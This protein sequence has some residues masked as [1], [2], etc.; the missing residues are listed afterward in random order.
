MRL[1]DTLMR[2]KPKHLYKLMRERYNECVNA[3]MCE[4]VNLE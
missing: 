4:L 2:Y 1:I 3:I